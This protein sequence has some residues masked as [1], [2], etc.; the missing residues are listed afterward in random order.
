MDVLLVDKSGNARDWTDLQEA[1]CYHP[2]GKVIC[3]LG[4]PLHTYTGGRNHTGEIS[5]IIV[6]SIMMVSGPV[7]GN[8]FYTRETIYAERDILYARDLFT[9][10]Y[11]GIQFP[12]HQLTIDHVTPK[13]HGGRHTWVNTVTACKSCNHGKRDRTPEQARMP[14]LYVPYAPSLQ[15]KLLLKNHKIKADQMAY[16][17]A[18]I[19]KK[20]RVWQNPTY[21]GRVN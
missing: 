15:E 11:C 9:C 20:S 7:F 21:N 2:R 16:L 10:C 3:D 13:A 5:T 18:N 14:L 17:L 4:T 12:Y 1:A 19:P 8:D 6:S